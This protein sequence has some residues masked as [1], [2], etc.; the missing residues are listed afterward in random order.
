MMT[1]RVI[2]ALPVTLRL[3]PCASLFLASSSGIAQPDSG[4]STNAGADRS[5]HLRAAS[6]PQAF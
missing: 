4:R 3:R 1:R 5:A 6:V 2:P